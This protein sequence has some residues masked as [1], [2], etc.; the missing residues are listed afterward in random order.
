MRIKRLH[1]AAAFLAFACLTALGQSA[2]RLR[3]EPERRRAV[4]SLPAFVRPP[5]NLD[6]VARV[7]PRGN[8][9]AVRGGH[10]R[11][12]RHMYMEYMV[13]RDGGSASLD[14]DAMASGKIVMVLHRQT[15]ACVAP[16]HT[17]P[18]G[19]ASGPAATA[20]IDEYQI[21]IQYTDFLTSYYDHLH[22]LDARLALPDWRDDHAGWVRVGP[23]N[24]LFL[25]A[26]GAMAPVPVDPGQRMG[27]TRNYFTTWDL[28]VVDT[29]RTAAFLGTGL[30][31][32]PTMPEFMAALA[33]SGIPVEPMGPGQPFPGE[34][35][36]N[37]ACF[38]DYLTPP[39]KTAWRAK[40]AGDGSC[41]R[42]DW[43]VAGTLQ[44]N[45]Y[46]A[47]V[48]APT[49]ENMFAAEVNVISFSPYNFDPA[50]QTQIGFGANFLDML[51]PT[52]IPA[53][54]AA[55]R[56]RLSRGLVFTTGR[57][58][59]TRQNPDPV[60]VHTGGYA[61]FDA[62][63]GQGG[64]GH[65][66]P[67]GVVVYLPVVSGQVHLKLRYFDAPCTS[68]LGSIESNLETTDWWG[69]YVR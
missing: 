38:T 21:F 6:Q 66:P 34:M 10:V 13:P 25:G 32:Y 16:D 50:N 47:D 29:R 68:L 20:L 60:T 33:A 18:S 14:V 26:N 7:I 28:G 53:A 1:F 19:C 55:A 17:V 11:P 69:D 43:D 40:L 65:L 4:G 51:P 35:S 67:H 9:N 46:R 52:A 63:D 44:G 22:S 64:P 48:T 41:G 23:M 37:S 36:V 30:L 57:T 54:I 62:P 45:W 49:L 27:A 39:L 15:E 8:M 12:V 56:Q 3:P 31:R 2:H 59:G 42:P 5:A 61:C 24:F 58:P